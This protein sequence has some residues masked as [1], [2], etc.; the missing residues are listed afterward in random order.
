MISNTIDHYRMIKQPGSG[1]MGVVYLAK[2]LRDGRQ[3][4][5]KLLPPELAGGK[6]PGGGWHQW[7]IQPLP[8]LPARAW[9]RSR[10]CAGFED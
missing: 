6:P 3:V 7:M 5:L 4:A 1:G 9:R 8:V 2:D 10:S